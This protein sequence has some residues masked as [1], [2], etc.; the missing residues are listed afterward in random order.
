[1]IHDQN[2]IRMK[3][4]AQIRRRIWIRTAFSIHHRLKTRSY[5]VAAAVAPVP[6]THQIKLDRMP[7]NAFLQGGAHKVEFYRRH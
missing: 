2:K 4:A 5:M 1:M 3:W 6:I 7:T